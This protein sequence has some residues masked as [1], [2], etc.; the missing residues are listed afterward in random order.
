[1]FV[2]ANYRVDAH[3]RCCCTDKTIAH[4]RR[5]M[6]RT[7]RAEE[8]A[9]EGTSSACREKLTSD[10][11]RLINSADVS[12]AQVSAKATCKHTLCKPNAILVTNVLLITRVM[13]FRVKSMLCGYYHHTDSFI[14]IHRQTFLQFSVIARTYSCDLSVFVLYFRIRTIF[15]LSFF[16][17][18]FFSFLWWFHFS[19]YRF[20]FVF[21][22]CLFL[23]WSTI[24]V[25]LFINHRFAKYTTE[26]LLLP[27][28]ELF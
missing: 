3:E 9:S 10:L 25:A 18:F 24:F 7:R 4:K 11:Y 14:F 28:G 27:N 15:V 12:A 21:F 19:F 1:M 16:S 26:K 17:F 22:V 2:R 6:W 8:V 5:R 13:N 23:V 20:F